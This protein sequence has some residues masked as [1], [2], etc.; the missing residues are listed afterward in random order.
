MRVRRYICVLGLDLVIGMLATNYNI[1]IYM[2]YAL[3]M[4]T[5]LIFF[6]RYFTLQIS[7]ISYIVIVISLYF[8]SLGMEQVEFETNR[9]WWIS[10]SVGFF[11]EAVAMTGICYYVA[12]MSHRILHKL[13]MSQRELSDK[14]EKI[15]KLSDQVMLALSSAVDAKDTYTNGHA[16]RV[17]EYATE[18]ADRLGKSDEE[19]EAIY[20]AALLHDVGKIGISDEIINKPGKLTEEEYDIIKQHTVIGSG[21]LDEISELPELSIGA[22][23]HHERYDGKGYPNGLSGE[24]IPENARII[25]VADCYDAMTSNRSYRKALEQEVVRNEIKKGIGTQF[26]PKIAEIMLDMIDEDIGYN[27]REK[28]E[29]GEGAVG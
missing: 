23:W 16:M 1:G 7:I 21:I 22:H 11:I 10:R 9:I 2:T 14:N 20:C 24:D 28:E 8:R 25:C 19:L 29:Y 15:K 12:Q 18:I 6:D 27:M 3:A 26:D 13:D 4:I 17:A 5:S